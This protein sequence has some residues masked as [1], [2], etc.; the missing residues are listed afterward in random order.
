MLNTKLQSFK[1]Q[2]IN[3]K[4]TKCTPNNKEI[5]Y[6][7]QILNLGAVKDLRRQQQTTNHKHQN[8]KL[9]IQNHEF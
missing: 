8:N 3:N 5:N 6:K 9:Q 7:S 1:P 2:T 4:R